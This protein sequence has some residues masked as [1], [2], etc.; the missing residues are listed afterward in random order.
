MPNGNF[1]ARFPDHT[2]T[3]PFAPETL[4]SASALLEDGRVLFFPNLP[5]SIE[6]SE[7]LFLSPSVSNGKSKN[8]SFNAM[9][10]ALGGVEPDT[11]DRGAADRM[12]AMMR[13]FSDQAAALVGGV[14]PGYRDSLERGMTSF[15]PLGVAGRKT[16]WRKDDTKLHVDAFPSRPV[17]GRRILRVFT[18]VG[19]DVRVWHLGEPFEDVVNKLGSTLRVPLPGSSWLLQSLRMTKGRR[20]AYDHLMLQLHNRMKAD[21]AYQR[22]AV[23]QRVS[24]PPASSWIVFTDQVSHAALAGQYAFEQTFFI[25]VQALRNPEQAPLRVLERAMRR[26]LV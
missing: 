5:F 9:T 12:K 26:S 1:V 22:D 24:F 10:G 2:W 15:R 19:Q 3:G 16:S 8:V 18:N 20:A 14:I 17:Q 25:P 4:A 13:R 6:D 21:D 7:R 11:F 23:Q